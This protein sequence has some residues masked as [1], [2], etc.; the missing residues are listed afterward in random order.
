MLRRAGMTA[1]STEPPSW[2]ESMKALAARYAPG[3]DSSKVAWLAVLAVLLLLPLAW[4]VPTAWRTFVRN[5]EPEPGGS[6]GRQVF[7]RDKKR[8]SG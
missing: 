8:R 4:I 5:E 2:P 3:V 7:G 6:L 1:P